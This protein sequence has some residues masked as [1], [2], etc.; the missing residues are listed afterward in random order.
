[1]K[2]EQYAEIQAQL[3]TVAGVVADMELKEFILAGERAQSIG[4]FIDQT[5]WMKGHKQL[6]DVISLA[7]AL[8]V[9][10]M[11]IEQQ[12]AEVRE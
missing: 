9:F 1:M 11:V 10:Q 6:E 3:L 12:M 4:P 7:I 5:L 8:R 2:K